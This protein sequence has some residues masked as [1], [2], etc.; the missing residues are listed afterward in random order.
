MSRHAFKLAAAGCIVGNVR[1]GT[2]LEAYSLGG[3]IK[4]LGRVIESIG[5]GT[6]PTDSITCQSVWVGEGARRAQTHTFRY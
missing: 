1:V 3:I 6:G 2:A 4:Y 5:F